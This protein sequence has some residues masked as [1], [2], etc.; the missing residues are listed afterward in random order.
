MLTLRHT[1][2]GA[3]ALPFVVAQT[4]DPQCGAA[5][6]Q[7]VRARIPDT[8]RAWTLASCRDYCNAAGYKTYAIR[9]SET[10][11]WC[12]CFPGTVANSVDT[13]YP[14]GSIK[15]YDIS[16]PVPTETATP[17]P[18]PVTTPTAPQPTSCSQ[19]PVIKLRGTSDD[20]AI[21]DQWAVLKRPGSLQ[22]IQWTTVENDAASFW[23]DSRGYLNTMSLG[24]AE[25]VIAI[26]REPDDN[27]ATQQVTFRADYLLEGDDYNSALVC[28]RDSSNALTCAPTKYPENKVWNRCPV[29]AG[30]TDYLSNVVR[31]EEQ[32]V[33]LKVTV[34]DAPNPNCP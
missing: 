30:F 19:G 9:I 17:T 11:P 20:G 8:G 28:S 13:S 24:G 29:P 5:G 14:A 18:F 21:Q 25:A 6:R 4:A 10:E 15:F 22:R 1:L 31:T 26:A 33:G 2:L 27:S 34:V 23:I 16:C 32:C 7:K 12:G 3:L